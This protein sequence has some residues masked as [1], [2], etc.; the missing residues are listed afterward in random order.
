MEPLRLRAPPDDRTE[1]SWS[2]SLR[3]MVPGGEGESTERGV[4]KGGGERERWVDGMDG[5]VRMGDH[6]L[7]TLTLKAP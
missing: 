1:A 7:V 5:P 4:A 3:G 2:K 6:Q